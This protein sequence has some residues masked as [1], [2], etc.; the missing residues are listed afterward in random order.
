MGNSMKLSPYIAIAIAC[1]YSAEIR[2]QSFDK[3]KVES[4]AAANNILKPYYSSCGGKLYAK[5]SDISFLEFNGSTPKIRYDFAYKISDSD[6][7]N[8]K[9]WHGRYS[10]FIGTAARSILKKQ[11]GGIDTSEWNEAREIETELIFENG[12]WK[13]D[14][15]FGVKAFVSGAWLPLAQNVQCDQ[16]PSH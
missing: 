2:A 6:R 1:I 10:L 11:Q 8:G 13:V 5:R 12:S 16:T 14:E 15:S 9:Q 4:I 7:L 3:L